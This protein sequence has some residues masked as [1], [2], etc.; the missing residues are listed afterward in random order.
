MDATPR[1]LVLHPSLTR[2]I[3][4][5]GGERRLVMPLWTVVML[6]IFGTH[7][8]PLT[9]SVALVVGIGGQYALIQAAKAD[10]YWFEIYLRHIRHQ[11]FYPAHGIV[12]TRPRRVPPSLELP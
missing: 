10:P 9:L 7:T 3:L 8:H 1:R 4:L 2:P 11:S 12:T 6:L 5:W